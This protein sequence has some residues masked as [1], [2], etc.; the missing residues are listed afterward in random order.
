MRPLV[1][2]AAIAACGH[3]E[4]STPANT[5]KPSN[6]PKPSNPAMTMTDCQAAIEA[7]GSADPTKL[8][9]IPTDCTLADVS[10]VL[11]ARGGSSNGT[12]GKGRSSGLSVHHFASDKLAEIH[13]WVDPKGHVVL[14]DADQ[15]PGP[16]AGYLTALG[17]PEAKLDY[18]YR[19][20]KLAGAEQLWL[21]RGIVVIA[22]SDEDTA[23]R[24]GVFAPTTLADY[25]ASLRYVDNETD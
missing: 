5:T 20:G 23:M 19:G 17:V 16:K 14:L 8:R 15:P 21:A 12:L 3:P 9:A 6:P 13:A 11:R 24:I 22:V 4:P 1:L 7:F 25:E 10:A 18:R 2:A